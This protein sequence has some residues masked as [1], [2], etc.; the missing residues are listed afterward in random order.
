MK[1]TII[2]VVYKAK[3]EDSKTYKSLLSVLNN[4]PALTK[5]LSIVI[6]DNSPEIQQVPTNTL[7]CNIIYKHDPR[8]LGLATAYNF[9]YQLGIE[10]KSDW[11]LLLDHDTTLNKQY[12]DNI[13]NLSDINRNEIAAVVPIIVCNNIVVSPVK[14][15]T[16]LPLKEERPAPGLQS[17]PMMA[18]NSGALINL[19]F[20]NKIGGFNME[21]PLDYLDHWLFHK[22]YETGYKALVLD[23]TLQHELSVMDF[24]SISYTRYQSI[25]DSEVKFYKNYKSE[26][27]PAYKKLMVKRL[28]KQILVGK[29]K[30]IAAYT[31]RKLFS[32]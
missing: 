25:L 16:L 8:N 31:L 26:F 10:N 3:L 4:E 29:N 12:L 24:N 9:A 28:I 27:F 13:L 18:I 11:L 19:E 6:Y 30:K 17:D 5:E 20:I 22:I 1:T 15:D 14:S 23:V 7:D 2:I 21:F 32:N